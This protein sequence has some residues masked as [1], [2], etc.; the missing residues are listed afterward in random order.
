MECSR[1]FLP[2]GKEGI[3]VGWGLVF[4]Y[5]PCSC[6]YAVFCNCVF[7]LVCAEEVAAS[8]KVKSAHFEGDAVIPGCGALIVSPTY[9]PSSR[10]VSEG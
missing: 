3:E 4:D 1:I 6:E 5:G 9:I 10:M 8:P 2:Q 7:P